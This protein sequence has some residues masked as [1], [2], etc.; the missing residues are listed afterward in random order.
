MNLAAL[1]LTTAPRTFIDRVFSL[2]DLSTGGEGVQ[3][4]FAREWPLWA[5]ALIVI[6]C[7][8]VAFWSYWR[9]TGPRAARSTFATLRTLTLVLLAAL[10]AGPQLVKQNERVEKDW[11]VLLADLSLIHI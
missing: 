6:F 1:L 7:A 2:R 9:I 5:W 3:F 4:Q 8:A 10:I 11:V